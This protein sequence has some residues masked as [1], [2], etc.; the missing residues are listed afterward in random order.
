MSSEDPFPE[1]VINA[2]IMSGRNV[3]ISVD[4][5]IQLFYLFDAFKSDIF[6]DPLL[7]P[8]SITNFSINFDMIKWLFDSDLL[9]LWTMGIYIFEHFCVGESGD[10]YDLFSDEFGDKLQ[11]EPSGGN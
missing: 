11:F 10:L 4:M 9:K 3:A 2:T 8:F 6:F 1:A 7:E 5:M